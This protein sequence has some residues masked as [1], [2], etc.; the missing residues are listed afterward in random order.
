ME[1][2]QTWTEDGFEVLCFIREDVLSRNPDV[3]SLDGVPAVE[4]V[5]EFVNSHLL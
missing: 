1:E 4:D 3:L 2:A 5:E